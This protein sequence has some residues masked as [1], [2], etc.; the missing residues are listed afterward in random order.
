VEREASVSSMKSTSARSKGQRQL[1]WDAP[2]GWVSY[3]E[4]RLKVCSLQLGVDERGAAT[5]ILIVKYEPGSHVEPHYHHADY[6]SIVV[7]GSI[8]VTRRSHGVGSMRVVNAGTVYGPLIAGPDGCTVIEVFATGVPDPSVTAANTY[9][10]SRAA[11][12][13]PSAPGS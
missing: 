6:C 7:E 2:G 10:E 13:R 4:K 8:E 11:A 3:P 9:V 1:T 12:I 5:T